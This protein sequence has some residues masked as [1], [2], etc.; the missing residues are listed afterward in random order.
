M[1]NDGSIV[2]LDGSSNLR[3]NNSVTQQLFIVVWHRNHISVLSAYP[4]T[5]SGSVYNYDF[6]TSINQAYGTDAQKHLGNNVYGMIGGDANADGIIDLADKVAW[7][8][9]AGTRGYKSGDFTLDG[10]VN[11]PD[12]N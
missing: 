9:Q 7:E 12:K 1:L 3:F 6:S 11:N 4:A 2:G 10:Q 5:S 8:G